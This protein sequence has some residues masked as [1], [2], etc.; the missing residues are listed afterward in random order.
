M[1]KVD[2]WWGFREEGSG[3]GI[4]LKHGK[5]GKLSKLENRTFHG[6]FFSK[7]SLAFQI[8]TYQK[9]IQKLIKGDSFEG[10]PF[11]FP[12]NFQMLNK[13]SKSREKWKVQNK[14]KNEWI[15][16]WDKSWWSLGVKSRKSWNL[17]SSEKHFH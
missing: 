7:N 4:M 16:S 8:K 13:I 14:G 1:Q 15:K 3:S 11:A 5:M 6:T 2:H 12:F 17:F 9:L 10:R